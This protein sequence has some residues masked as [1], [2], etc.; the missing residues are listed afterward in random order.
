MTPTTKKATLTEISEA[1]LNRFVVQ[2]ALLSL[3]DPVRGQPTRASLDESPDGDISGGQLLK[4][5]FLDSF[6]LICSTSSS[7]AE[8]ASAVCLEQYAPAGGAVLRVARNRGLTPEVL[9]GLERV[10]QTLRVVARKGTY[11]TRY[12][13]K[14]TDTA[15]DAEKSSAEAEPEILRLIVEL[16]RDR[17][18]SIAQR[19]AKHGIRDFLRET[20][21]GLLADQVKTETRAKL[22]FKP[23]LENCPFT[24]AAPQTW[25]PATMVVL[26]S[27]A[28]QARWHYSEQL[29]SLL[30]LN[31]I[32]NP[33]WLDSLHKIARYHAAI[34]S[35]IKLAAKQPEIFASIQIRDVK[36]PNSRSFSLSREGAPLLANVKRLVKE[37]PG[38]I[39]EKLE[40]H[41]GTH[42]AEAQLRR[43]CRL[44]LTL[45]A[46][47]QLVV[48]YEG[49]PTLAPRMP[50]IGTSKKACF[51]CYEYL[52]Q[53]PLGL[54]A[55]AC[56]QKIY[57]TWMPPPF[58]PIP[59][60]FKSTPFM[61]LGKKIEQ[62]NRRELK[63]AL[64]APR[65]PRNQDSTAGPSLTITA[66]TP[67]GFRSQQAAKVHMSLSDGSLSEN[68]E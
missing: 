67:S 53:H 58:Y 1:D 61:K 49:H 28:S 57:P 64:T 13:L 43:A 55:L 38:M 34:K 11:P 59:G 36:A 9:T 50:F 24:A 27:W 44:D 39:M 17:I 62:L 52:L 32:Q 48:F 19:V 10:L 31:Q 47:M 56:H 66:T 23:W 6:A 60:Q 51:L 63:T 54:Q 42:D 5:K 12:S 22:G 8:T 68:W 4:Q 37:D 45:H 35:M 26:I 33:P 3:I 14:I 15:G 46:E 40:K 29:Q 20:R 18:L 30:E 65:R 41:L 25:D 7:G 2:S 16:D 21:S